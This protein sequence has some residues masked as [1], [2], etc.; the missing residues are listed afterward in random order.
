MVSKL[1][2]FVESFHQQYNDSIESVSHHFQTLQS[3]EQPYS[4]IKI[5]IPNKTNYGL[6]ITEAINY[7]KK[8]WSAQF[9][10]YTR[11]SG[12]YPTFL[13][14]KVYVLSIPKT[15]RDAIR[16]KYPMAIFSDYKAPPEHF[17]LKVANIPDSFL[18]SDDKLKALGCL[19]GEKD[20]VKAKVCDYNGAYLNQ[21]LFSFSK[22]PLSALF[23]MKGLF[24]PFNQFSNPLK[25]LWN[26]TIS[27]NCCKL[28]GHTTEFC[29]F[30]ELSITEVEQISAYCSSI[31]KWLDFSF[32]S[33]YNNTQDSKRRPNKQKFNSNNPGTS[34]SFISPSGSLDITNSNKSPDMEDEVQQNTTSNNVSNPNI[35]ISESNTSINSI[36]HIKSD[37]SESIILEQNTPIK[38]S[39]LL[40]PQ[41]SNLVSSISQSEKEDTS[42]S[43]KSPTKTKI[44]SSDIINSTPKALKKKVPQKGKNTSSN[45][46]QNPPKYRY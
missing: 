38:Q 45:R 32:V 7:L 22:V 36:S 12:K 9:R 24:N 39:L 29:P 37:S 5:N 19:L 1:P 44:I 14:F 3:P 40:S 30:P 41:K 15:A 8:N 43:L 31:N 16:S 2:T 21:A 18:D 27:C 13:I 6:F 20:Y 4:T 11:F 17:Q 28:I 33:S 34:D 26:R 10:P 25:I 42:L 35:I 46:G 23:A